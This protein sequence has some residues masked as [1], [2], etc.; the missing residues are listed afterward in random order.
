MAW[1]WE[2]LKEQQRG[3]SPMPPQM[4]DYVK[5]MRELKLPGGTP[6]IIFIVMIFSN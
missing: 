4:D 3:R 6:I 2:R 1:D 5:K